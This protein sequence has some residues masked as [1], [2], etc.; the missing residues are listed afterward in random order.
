MCQ[1]ER[2][3]KCVMGTNTRVIFMTRSANYVFCTTIAL[4]LSLELH[5]HP[6]RLPDKAIKVWFPPQ[7]HTHFSNPNLGRLKVSM[8]LHHYLPHTSITTV[9]SP[10]FTFRSLC[11]LR[12]ITNLSNYCAPSSASALVE[13]LSI[14]K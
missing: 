14:Q 5:L 4:I 11:E 1:K 3:N 9:T 12:F 7:C 6:C 13:A 8:Y 10:I 2:P